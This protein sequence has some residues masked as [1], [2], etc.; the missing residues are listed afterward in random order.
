MLNLHFVLLFLVSRI[1]FE[2]EVPEHYRKG[3]VCEDISTE[4][5]N[6]EIACDIETA[7]RDE[8]FKSPMVEAALLNAYAESGFDPFA[9]GDK[10]KSKGVFQL[11]KGGLGGTMTDA[12][13]YNVKTSVRR[14]SVAIR[15]S[16]RLQ[17]AIESGAETSE[18]TEL[19]CIEIM[20]PSDKF[21]KA[22]KRKLLEGLVFQSSASERRPIREPET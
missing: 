17:R 16:T 14:V 18:L 21:A 10:G 12:E 2:P 20:R 4:I 5:E 22:R 13:R 7:M 15:K 19:F 6:R 3:L 1:G 8:G 9:V 11:R